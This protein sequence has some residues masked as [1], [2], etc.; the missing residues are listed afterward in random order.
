MLGI[1]R[2]DLF[3]YALLTALMLPWPLL[4]CHEDGLDRGMVMMFGYTTA[5][6]VIT[7]LVQNEAA[8]SLSGGYR[9]LSALPVSS[10][11]IVDAKHLLLAV[12]TVGQTLYAVAIVL[13]LAGPGVFVRLSLAYLVVNCAG[14][15]L[16][17]AGL[18]WV[19]N[20][21]RLPALTKLVAGAVTL[22]LGLILVGE[23]MV[24][25][26]RTRGAF[27]PADLARYASWV[28]PLNVTLA[29]LSTAALF[30][31]ILRASI[32]AR[33]KKEF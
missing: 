1:F 7:A 29:A 14:C 33:E 13:F 10:R 16:L 11:E 30:W 32:A 15:L 17:G 5:L 18:H 23:F 24:F 19:V 25:A 9:F 20:R 8:E 12:F 21:F 26:R 22:I 28:T 6:S 4:L 2:K 27:S 31:L 3:Q